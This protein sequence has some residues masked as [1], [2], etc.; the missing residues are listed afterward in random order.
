M[1]IITTW[2]HFSTEVT[3]RGF[4]KC[5]I[6]STVGESD[7]DKLWNGSEEMQMLAVNVRKRKVLIVKRDNDAGKGRQNLTYC[8][9]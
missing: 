2:E 9:Y 1:G 7:G 8:V 3:V 6:S 4:K 5:C